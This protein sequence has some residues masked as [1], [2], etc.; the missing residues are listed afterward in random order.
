MDN[1]MKKYIILACILIQLQMI[2]AQDNVWLAGKWD[3]GASTSFGLAQHI[4]KPDTLILTHIIPQKSF[5]FGLGNL[6]I[7]RHDSLL[8]YSNGL[9]IFNAA[10]DTMLNAQGFNQYDNIYLSFYQQDGD[11]M[12]NWMQS[13]LALPDRLDSTRYHL[14]H[15]NF[16]NIFLPNGSDVDFAARHVDHSIIDLTIDG[17]LGGLVT[18]NQALITKDVAPGYLTACKHGSGKGWWILL[19]EYKSNGFYRLLFSD[20][21]ITQ[22][23]YQAIGGNRPGDMGG[24]AIF[25]QVG[26]RYAMTHGDYGNIRLYDF[27][28]CRGLLSNPRMWTVPLDLSPIE[29][30]WSISFSPSGRFLYATTGYHIYQY[31]TYASDIKASE[32]CVATADGYLCLGLSASPSAFVLS[33]LAPNGEIW[34]SSNGFCKDY[35]IIRSP[36]SVG[37]ACNIEQRAI[38][39][40]VF[41]EASLPLYPNYHLGALPDNPC[42]I[43]AVATDEPQ[44]SFVKTYPNPATDNITF[45]WGNLIG[46]IVTI[47]IYDATGRLILSENVPA[48]KGQWECNVKMWSK[49]VYAYT[50]TADVIYTGKCIVE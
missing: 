43:Y 50:L 48:E 44:L 49:G 3:P 40:G 27:D 26:T 34:I 7:S 12:L 2:Y 10:H 31:D 46:T 28:R 1:L 23:G 9:T 45:E 17:G 20:N 16:E 41:T 5:E 37:L 11:N 24:V 30:L 19:P 36:D 42:P 32:V 21:G 6:S 29:S 18:K 25:D 15:S 4:F 35:H 38:Q 39:N 13:V 47:S 22:E 14:I 33:Q 8:F